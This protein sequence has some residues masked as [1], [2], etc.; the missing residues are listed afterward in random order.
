MRGRRP[1]SP[2]RRNTAQATAPSTSATTN[3]ATWAADRLA[4]PFGKA[5]GHSIVASA[6][7]RRGNYEDARHH[8]RHALDLCRDLGDRPLEADILN[9]FGDA[10]HAA[11]NPNAAQETWQLARDILTDLEHPHADQ[12][13]GKLALHSDR[14]GRKSRPGSASKGGTS[15]TSH[16][17]TARVP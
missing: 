12:I 17:I 9:R 2:R 15:L 6:R 4:D 8:L 14:P 3:T 13:R 10:H 7:L 1:T 11:H 5:I 16:L